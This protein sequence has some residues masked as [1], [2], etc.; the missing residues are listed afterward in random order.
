MLVHNTNGNV[1]IINGGYVALDSSTKIITETNESVTTVPEDPMCSPCHCATQNDL[2]NACVSAGSTLSSESVLSP[3]YGITLSQVNVLLNC[4]L[5]KKEGCTVK[6]NYAM[7]Q[8]NK[9]VV[10]R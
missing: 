2:I 8:S 6:A 10:K 9:K 3:P 7:N 1:C 4:W 5:P